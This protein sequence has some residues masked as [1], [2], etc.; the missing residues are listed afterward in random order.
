MLELAVFTCGVALCAVGLVLAINARA[1]WSER[2]RLRRFQEAMR[3][4]NRTPPLPD[5]RE[6]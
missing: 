4:A 2:D 3:A 1:E 6:E 5:K